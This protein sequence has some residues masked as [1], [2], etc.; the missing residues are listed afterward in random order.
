MNTRL[1]HRVAAMAGLVLAFASSP[2]R[3]EV[4]TVPYK[5]A[6]Q[7]AD[8]EAHGIE[9][10]AF[11]KVGVDVLAEGAALEY[12]K[13]R[14][15]PISILVEGHGPGVQGYGGYHTYAET[16]AAITTMVTNYPALASKTVIGLSLEGRNITMLKISDNVAVDEDEAEVLYMGNHHA[17]EIMSVEIPLRFAEYLLANYG[18]NATIT[19]YIDN[20]EIFF[21]PMVNPDGHVWV[22][23]HMGGD[24][25][26]WWRKNRRLNSDGSRGVDLNRNYGYKWGYDNVGS[27]PT[28]SS[29][30]Y[31]GPF[32]FSEP[33]TQVIRNFVATRQFKTWLTYHSYGE[34]L[35]YGWGYIYGN[36]P[37]HAAIAALADSLVE[38]NG[39]LA[40]NPLSGAIYLTNGDADDWGYGEQDMKPKIFAYTPEINSSGQ[41][42]FG[43]DETMIQPTFN[44]LLPMNMKLLKFADNPYR[45]V[46][47]WAP[48]QNPVADP[49]DN[50]VCRVSWQAQDVN[51]PN[52]VS[53][54]D[55]E[56]CQNPTTFVDPATPALDGWTAGGFTYSGTGFTGGG[57]WSGNSNGLFST[58]TM[59]LPLS[60]DMATDSLTFKVT[61]NTE[62]NYDYGYVDVS[63]DGGSTWK[64]IQGNISTNSNPNGLNRG[65]GFTGVSAG[66]V[67]AIF[68][69]IAYLGKDIM[70]RFVYATDGGVLGTFGV[71]LDNI[72]PVASCENV[73]IVA[74]GVT[75]NEHDYAVP[76]VGLWRFRVRGIDAETHQ[77]PWSNSEDRLV[78]TLTD[79]GGARSYRSELGANYPNP[80]NPSTQIPF[81]VGGAVGG[82]ETR[83]ELIVYSVAGARVATLV[84]DARRPGTYVSRWNGSDDAGR[85]VA[86]GIYFARLTVGMESP[87]TRKLVLLK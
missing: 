86:S 62:A 18:I 63:E 36:T 73:S 87:I 22:E 76:E 49:F 8:F 80:F 46:G 35:L 56:A 37:D 34:L 58:L 42:G 11:T 75:G 4:V 20:R 69:L 48:V 13:T 33:E 53:S 66:W 44:L 50:A 23:G 16:E 45:V 82:S 5:G 32:A 71:R 19:N 77:S 60:V 65:H 41:G 83:V 59:A 85:P 79:A 30:T 84:R 51:D 57:Y 12:L 55:I 26:S 28:P 78:E 70:I 43:P 1:P 74:S 67:D 31:R 25:S 27:S 81:V 72:A 15:Y 24:P 40:G 68:P 21:V 3:S 10:L 7:M 14:P 29:E 52:P 39:Y 2:I 9:V 64:P 6:A 61:Y 54:Y 38:E 17:R 47:P